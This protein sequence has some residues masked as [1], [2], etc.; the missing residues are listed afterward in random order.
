MT[1]AG[2]EMMDFIMLIIEPKLFIKASGVF[3]GVAS[4]LKPPRNF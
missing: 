3:K 1:L 2:I 4:G